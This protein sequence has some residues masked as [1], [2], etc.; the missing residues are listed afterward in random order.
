MFFYF[1]LVCTLICLHSALLA[2]LNVIY[3]TFKWANIIHVNEWY[4]NYI[5]YCVDFSFMY[6]NISA[7]IDID[8][9][10]MPK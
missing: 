3:C 10:I 4:N 9:I 2:S 1:L 6:T 8:V 5:C 7:Y